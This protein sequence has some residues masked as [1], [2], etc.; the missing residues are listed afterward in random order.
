MTFVAQGGRLCH[1][2]ERSFGG[3]CTM[4][5]METFISYLVTERNV[6]ENTLLS[7]RRDLRKLEDYCREQSITRPAQVSASNLQSYLLFLEDE[8]FKAATIS[9]SVASIHA[10]FQYLY[11]EHLVEEDVSESLQAPKIEKRPP[12]ILTVEEVNR[13]LDQPS[14]SEPK[15]LRDKAMLE[16]L[17]ATG[18]RVS[19]L[20]DLKVSDVNLSVGIVSCRE[21]E[22]ERMIPFGR[23]V[24][25]ALQQYMT[26]ARARL[27]KDNETD[28]LFVNISGK[29]M[30]RQGFWKI[31]KHYGDKAGIRKDITPQSLRNSFAA[32]LVQSG[33]DMRSVQNML[34]HSDLSV[35]HAFVSGLG[36]GTGA[37][38][39]VGGRKR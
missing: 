18:I 6:S 9:R 7:Y 38:R 25:D 27:L 30:S 28:I 5:E 35:T 32:N 23:E 14:G 34:G 29:A 10:F 11:R 15:D 24:Q 1:P 26:E 22:H 2:G 31:I 21:S 33:A 36:A 19:E 4:K 39:L 13:L 20:I 37:E 17:Y 12:E 3:S 8:H 16:L